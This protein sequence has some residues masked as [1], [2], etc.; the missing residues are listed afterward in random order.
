MD[1]LIDFAISLV[2]NIVLG[3]MMGSVY[4]LAAMGLAL[5]FGVANL[6]NFAH[7][8]YVMLAMYMAYF[9][10]VT[11]VIDPVV[12]SIINIPLFFVIGLVTYLLFFKRVINAPPL[13][14]I[15]VTVG[16]LVLLRNI[17][18]VIWQAEPKAPP[19]TIFSASYKIG[20]III[21]IDKLFATI[22]SVTSL[23]L[24]YL[25][26]ER[27]KFGTAM[28]AAADDVDAVSMMG[29][30]TGRLFLLTLGISMMLVGLSGSLIMMYQ[31]VT[32][33]SGLL[34]GLL[35][36][37]IVALAGL[38]SIRGIY[39]AAVIFGLADALASG[40]WDPRGREI[41]LYGLFILIL[42]L[43]PRGLWGRR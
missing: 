34:F 3:I 8:E 26:L 29:I 22:I 20:P 17:A 33:T 31:A 27:S 12:S 14:Q 7:G 39:I 42:W 2:R 5:L 32:P 43:K 38:G 4:A 19:F 10:S 24:L 36:W 15:A 25:F 28:R 16:V 40:L 37:A 1:L 23:I 9:F 21:P 13:S 6:I 35:S 18:L 30:D 11:L 41:I